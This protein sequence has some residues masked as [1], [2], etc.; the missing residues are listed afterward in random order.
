MRSL[1]IRGIKTLYPSIK[2][3]MAFDVIV[4]ILKSST[5]IG[6]SNNTENLYTY[7]FSNK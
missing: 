6:H 4:K 7:Q 3:L 2:F 1:G 5:E